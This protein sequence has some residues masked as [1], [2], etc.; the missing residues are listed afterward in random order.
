MGIV[1][2]EFYQSIPKRGQE[3]CG[4]NVEI[5]KNDKETIVVLSDGLGSGIKANIL[6]TLTSKIAVGL[7]DK[8]LPLIEIIETVLATLPICEVREIAYSTLAV[9]RV[10]RNGKAQIIEIDTPSIFLVRNGQVKKIEMQE[11]EMWGKTVRE[12][13]V[14]LENDDKLFMVSDGVIHAG[15]GA[16]LDFGLGW[17]GFARHLDDVLQHYYNL[18]DIVE[19]LVDIC[20]AYYLMEP[21]DDF[22]VLGLGFREE[23][24]LT[25]LS[26]PTQ[27]PQ[28]DE[29]VVFELLEGPGRKVV[30]GGTTASIVA[31]ELNQKVKSTF[32]YHDK[33]VPPIMKIKGMD[34]VTEGLL[35][36]NKTADYLANH[37]QGQLYPEGKD[38]AARLVRMLL[39]SDYIKMIVGRAM[40]ESHQSLNLPLELGI[41]TQVMN[42]IAK[43]LK[44]LN[45]EVE[46]SWY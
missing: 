15:I 18:K 43:S 44:K 25:M 28:K 5:I 11:R 6:S 4:D 30:S 31:R 27:S 45:K 8:K 2:D 37:K 7:I 39:A 32:E 38:G 12:A 17:Q 23:R 22:T 34:L 46:I 19:K 24:S 3:V 1:I 14:K 10:N 21:G 16:L 42:R 35:T 13:E 26:G 9:L 29:E 41:R 36:L 40:N 33:A 20:L